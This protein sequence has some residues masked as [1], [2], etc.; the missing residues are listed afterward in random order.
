MDEE[1]TDVVEEDVIEEEVYEGPTITDI[2]DKTPVGI[3]FGV[4]LGIIILSGVSG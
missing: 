3:L 4:G 2:L 1:P